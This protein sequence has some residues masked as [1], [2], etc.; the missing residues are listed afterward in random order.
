VGG[1]IADGIDDR[2]VAQ[3]MVQRYAGTALEDVE[4]VKCEKGSPSEP[5]IS[6]TPGP[7]T[8]YGAPPITTSCP[9]PRF[10]RYV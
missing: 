4:A 3:R 2:W 7:R 8:M 5:G 1:G 6:N 9:Q 10:S